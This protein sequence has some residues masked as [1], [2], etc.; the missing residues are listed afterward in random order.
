MNEGK[1][2]IGAG[3]AQAMARLGIHE[4]GAA[5]TAESNIAQPTEMGVFGTKTPGEVWADRRESA[6]EVRSPLEEARARA[7]ATVE[8]E[9]EKGPERDGPDPGD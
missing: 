7:K 9:P 2:K 5:V 8:A 3:H 4:L 1:P 6:P